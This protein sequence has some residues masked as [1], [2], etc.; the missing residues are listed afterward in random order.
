MS[1]PHFSSGIGKPVA[2]SGS[3]PLSEQKLPV[4]LSKGPHIAD[5]VKLHRFLKALGNFSFIEPRCQIHLQ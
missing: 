2:N 3:S 4:K 5:S 1:L